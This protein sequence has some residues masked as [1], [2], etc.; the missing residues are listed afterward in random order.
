MTILSTVST[1]ALPTVFMNF[2]VALSIGNATSGHLKPYT[3][4]GF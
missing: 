2:Y 3:P 4:L 1:T